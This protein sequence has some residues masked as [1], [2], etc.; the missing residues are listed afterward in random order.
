MAMHR[1]GRALPRIL[2]KLRSRLLKTPI[3][4]SQNKNMIIS[5]IGMSGVGKTYWSKKLEKIGWI[6]FSVDDLIEKKL[7]KE[8]KS[9][10]FAGIADVAKWMEQP[11][12]KHYSQRSQIY[13]QF[14][15]ESMENIFEKIKRI[16]DNKNVVIDTT[17]SVI[18]T[19]IKIMLT[20]SRLSKIINLSIPKSVQEKMY[21]LYLE[22]PKPV[23]WGDV[24]KK[25]DGESDLEALSLY[26]PKLLQY[27]LRLYKKYT[28]IELNYF[29]LRRHGFT[30]ND[31]LKLLI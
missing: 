25:T 9:S 18:Y 7:E 31:F 24:F 21:Q 28:H 2:S 23:I 16:S 6:R 5:L 15:K 8:L 11:F 14:E 27:R 4:A 12:E 29:E 30:V 17:G 26:Y 13:L 22:E 3:T 10:G 20:L 19:G 1:S